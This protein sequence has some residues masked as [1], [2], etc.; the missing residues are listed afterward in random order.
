MTMNELMAE[1]RIRELA[2]LDGPRIAMEYEARAQDRR[3]HRGVRQGVAAALVRLG[4]MLDRGAGE[5]VATTFA[6]GA[7]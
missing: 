5:R 2:R 4:I 3:R 1:T 6:H 7:R